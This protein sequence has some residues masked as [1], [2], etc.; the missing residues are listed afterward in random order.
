MRR[1]SAAR[2]THLLPWLRPDGKAQVT[3][4]YHYGRPVRVDTV[5][6]SAQHDPTIEHEEL[7]ARSWNT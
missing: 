2:R 5:V 6:V 7:S 4:E 3:V 1:L